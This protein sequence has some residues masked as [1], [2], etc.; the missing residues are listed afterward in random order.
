MI[1][2]TD[3]P[4]AQRPLRVGV[5]GGTFDPPHIGHLFSAL[6]AGHELRLDHVLLV[7]ANDPWQ[8]SDRLVTPAE[9]RLSM[10]EAAIEDIDELEASRIELDRGGATYTAD[11][12][13][14]LSEAYRTEHGPPELF[15]IV[16]SD[17]AAGL[18]TWKRP[19]VLRTLAKI[20]VLNRPGDGDQQVPPAG[21]KFEIVDLP[22]LEVSGTTLRNR[23][24]AG[25]PIDF[26]TP[27]SVVRQIEAAGL[28]L[29]DE[30]SLSESR[31]VTGEQQ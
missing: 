3:E 13:E 15:L 14:F 27:K 6:S 12:L 25:R 24:A 19:E 26:L 8:K 21:W 16:G 7:V 30:S 23:V 4:R 20:V 22:G 17:A 9:I 5:F 11:T 28:Y 31:S 29:S 18:D 10:V 1:D 2:T